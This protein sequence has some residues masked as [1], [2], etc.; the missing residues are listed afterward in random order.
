MIFFFRLCSLTYSITGGTYSRI[1]KRQMENARIPFIIWCV[2]QRLGGAY[3]SVH[4]QIV[5]FVRSLRI[6]REIMLHKVQCDELYDC[7][8]GYGNV[9]NW[10]TSCVKNFDR[11]FTGKEHFN[12]NIGYSGREPGHVHGGNVRRLSVLFH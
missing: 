4:V 11:I 5:E 3:L 7:H 9:T 6:T 1:Q 2:Q 10:N 12:M 8:D